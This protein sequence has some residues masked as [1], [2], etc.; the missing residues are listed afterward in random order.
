MMSTLVRS[1]IALMS[2]LCI[3]PSVAFGADPD[4]RV[5]RQA[6]AAGAYVE[7][8][9]EIRPIV[10]QN[11]THVPTLV[12][13]AQIFLELER[14]DSAVVFATLAYQEEDEV[15]EVVQTYARALVAANRAKEAT[16]A[17]RTF[18]KRNKDDVASALVLVDALIAADSVPAAEL[19]ATV[20]KSKNPKSADASLA[21]GNIYFSYKPMP[22]Y[23]LAQV[24]YE[25]A[26]EAN[27]NMVQAHFNLAQV[28]WQ[29]ANRES[30]KELSNTYFKRSLLSWAEVSKLDPNNARAYF[31]QGKILY[32]AKKYKD[33]AVA[34]VQYRKLRPVGTGNPMASWYL[35]SA[36]YELNVCDSA[37]KHLNDAVQQIDSVR[38]TAALYMARCSF[39]SKNWPQ[40]V[41]KY[42]ALVS[43]DKLEGLDYWF[44]GT[45]LVL[46]GDTTTAITMMD[47][48]AELDP[49]QAPL[50][51]R[52][53]LLLN[54]RGAYAA[55]TRIFKQRLAN[56]SDS[57]DSRI[58]AL[59]GNN[60]FADSLVDSARTYYGM[61]EA[62][63]PSNLYVQTRLAEVDIIQ[64][65]TAEANTRLTAVATKGETSASPEDRKTAESALQRLSAVALEAK[66]WPS[67][68]ATAKRWVALNPKSS[69]AHLYLAIG[70]QGA[71]SK[72]DACRS[73]KKV[74][75][76]DPGS[77]PAKDNLKALGC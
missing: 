58:L 23:D 33:A 62:K 76:L 77:A 25:E 38:T 2:V 35:G 3:L 75:E 61:A 6:V 19:V 5:V 43:S 27:P 37:A 70:Y 4:L 34:L 7:A 55:S 68:Q 46:T 66:D 57:L 51:F 52:F 30:D 74:L 56:V 8:A 15:A 73:Y 40:V 39:R 29:L 28:Y 53:G 42:A 31:E 69:Y 41:A 22:V 16:V 13:A 44:Y 59:I 17:M 18:M 36:F 20:V 11:R 9:D 63:D 14:V 10:Q 54:G 21:L 72:D 50:M 1:V 47:K 26:I 45:A 24:N 12:L 32:L 71:G 49:R 67:L 65:K 48:A 60:F 64:G